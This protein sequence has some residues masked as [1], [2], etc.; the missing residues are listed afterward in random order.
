M[1]RCLSLHPST[2]PPST[3]TPRRRILAKAEHMNPGG[4][5]KDRPAAFLIRELER[6]GR[7]VPREARKPGDLKGTIVEGTGGNTGIG[8]ALVAAAKGY[9]AV[10]CMPANIADEKI[11]LM[12]TL[13]AKVR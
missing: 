1:P 12:K 11:Q 13:G 3:P 9:D 7:L 2:P 10:F 8:M 5:I 6:A 4:S